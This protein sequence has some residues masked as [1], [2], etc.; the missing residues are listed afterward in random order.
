MFIQAKIKMFKQ[1]GFSDNYSFDGEIKG[2]EKQQMIFLFFLQT[3]TI[4]EDLICEIIDS[5]D[6]DL[7]IKKSWNWIVNFHNPSKFFMKK[8][9]DKLDWSE[10]SRRNKNFDMDFI[11]EMKNYIDFSVLHNNENLMLKIT[12][13][14]IEEMKDYFNLDAIAKH[15]QLSKKFILKYLGNEIR[16]RTIIKYQTD[17]IDEI[18]LN[19]YIDFNEIISNYYNGHPLNKNYPINK[20]S[21][22]QEFNNRKQKRGKNMIH[23]EKNKHKEDTK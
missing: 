21:L 3:K 8:Y 1:L 18:F 17:F 12:E 13:N 14:F 2:K 20:R 9:K 15:K 23:K 19:K 4:P 16:H 5:L 22:I 6:D 11:R 10:L 7:I